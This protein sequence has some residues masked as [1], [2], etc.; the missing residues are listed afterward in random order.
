MKMTRQ[1]RF[2]L[3]EEAALW[4]VRLGED[5]QPRCRAEFFEWVR[6]SPRNMEEFMF[7]KAVSTRFEAMDPKRE[8]AIDRIALET[9]GNDGVI[10]IGERESRTRAV[11][12]S[13]KRSWMIGLAASLAA[14]LLGWASLE[15]FAVAIGPKKVYETSTGNQQSIKLG[16]GSLMQLNTHSRAAVKFSKTE[17]E[18]QLLDGEALFVVARDLARPFR[19]VAGAA[20]IEAIG[21]QFNV[22][23]RPEG[24][25]VSVV[26][27]AVQVSRH[28]RIGATD[29]GESVR[30]EAGAEASVTKERVVK[31][32]KPDVKRAI[33]WRERSL[34][35]HGTRLDEVVREFNRYNRTPIRL[36]GAAAE[37]R[38][39]GIFDAD[40]PRPLIEFLTRQPDFSVRQSENEVV[41]R[42]RER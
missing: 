13:S 18:V 17:R 7:A 24:T 40:D 42:S 29:A 28:S 20:V 39:S 3:S 10:E 22:Y 34:V 38:I 4:L 1:E 35:F 12:A 27:G 11:A 21:T 32:V 5:P 31:N 30:L 25:R 6:Q 16:D 8:I 14:I 9:L 37:R 36:D 23:R 2:K 19:V 41:I 33:A 15:F 26:E